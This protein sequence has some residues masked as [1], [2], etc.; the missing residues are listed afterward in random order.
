MERLIAV[1]KNTIGSIVIAAV[2]SL[3]L[4]FPTTLCWNFAVIYLWRF[5]AISIF[6]ASCLL[7]LAVISIKL[8]KNITN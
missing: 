7:F 2:I 6:Q 4:S 1:F 3:M 5:P 8:F